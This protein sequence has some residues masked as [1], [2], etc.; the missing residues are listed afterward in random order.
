MRKK[1]LFPT[2]FL[3]HQTLILSDCILIMFSSPLPILIRCRLPVPTLTH[4][5]SKQALQRLPQPAISS[6]H[7]QQTMTRVPT[8]RG[9]KVRYPAAQHEALY[10]TDR[11]QLSTVV[12]NDIFT[13]CTPCLVTH[14]FL[15]GM[16]HPDVSRTM[17]ALKWRMHDSASL[18][19]PPRCS[20]FTSATVSTAFS[21]N[22]CPSP[23]T[24]IQHPFCSYPTTAGPGLAQAKLLASLRGRRRG[25]G[26]GRDGTGL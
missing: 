18:A 15:E 8:P 22:I 9:Q 25:G 16:S 17:L 23:P 7:S 19:A 21:A 11:R 20:S 3:P 13:P 26:G 4:R 14:K 6:P 24:Q 5:P 2:P 12:I 10:G 1:L